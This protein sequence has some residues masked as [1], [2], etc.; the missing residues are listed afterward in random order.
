[1][2]NG[3]SPSWRCLVDVLKVPSVGEKQLAKTVKE[4]YCSPDDQSN[5]NESEVAVQ[6]KSPQGK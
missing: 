3:P 5:F 6:A 1:M 4:K 2:R